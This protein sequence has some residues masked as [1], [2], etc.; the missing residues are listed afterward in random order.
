MI[1]SIVETHVAKVDTAEP[2]L[3]DITNP[4]RS[5][6]AEPKKAKPS[7]TAFQEAFSRLREDQKIAM[8]QTEGLQE[9]FHQLDTS[10]TT[11]KEDSPFRKGI[12]KLGPALDV[13]G[14]VLTLA[15]PLAALDPVANTAFG[16]VQSV[17]KVR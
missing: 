14:G 17:M 16:I 10:N 6:L 11:S 1:E 9:L 4:S 8:G 5:S 2:S 15:T 13:V 12:R 3:V 7:S